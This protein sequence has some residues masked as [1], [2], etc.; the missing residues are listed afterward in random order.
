MDDWGLSAPGSRGLQG[1]ANVAASATG[2][3]VLGALTGLFILA[4]VGFVIGYAF[5]RPGTGALIGI[6]TGAVFG[7]LAGVDG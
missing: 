5:D 2:G 6:G 4:P 1:P 7:A 3:A